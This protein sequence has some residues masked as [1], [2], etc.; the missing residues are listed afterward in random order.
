MINID[1]WLPIIEI[2][3]MSYDISKRDEAILFISDLIEKVKF[4]G[5]TICLEK[6]DIVEEN[7]MHKNKF[8][9]I[10]RWH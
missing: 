8:T 5:E 2:E 3:S 7:G 6:V 1:V 9:E 4:S 10:N